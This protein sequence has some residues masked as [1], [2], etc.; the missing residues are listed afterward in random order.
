MVASTSSPL[1]FTAPPRSLEATFD[2]E[3]LT[4]DGGLVWLQKAD[5]AL[6]EWGGSGPSL[7]GKCTARRV[8]V[9][10]HESD[11]IE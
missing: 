4:S 5:D 11:L 6:Y 9:C 1:R 8:Q 10:R 7:L 3:G 2:L